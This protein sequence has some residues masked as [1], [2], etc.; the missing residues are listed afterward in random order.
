MT[1]EELEELGAI[2]GHRFAHPERLEQ[3]SPIA[4]DARTTLP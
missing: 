4:R 1:A 2:L 3:G